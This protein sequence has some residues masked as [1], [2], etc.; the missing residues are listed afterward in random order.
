LDKAKRPCSMEKRP[1]FSKPLATGWSAVIACAVPALAATLS[2]NPAGATLIFEPVINFF[3]GTGPA[4]NVFPL[5]DPTYI[6]MAT[7]EQVANASK[8]GE[9]YKLSM[10]F[11]REEGM[12]NVGMYNNTAY[13]IT[14]LT[15]TIVGSSDE[16]DLGV[17]WVVTPDPNVDAF[18]D[19]ANNDGKVG[20]SDIFST[21]TVSNGGRTLTLSDGLIPAGSHFTDYIFSL[22]TDGAPSAFAALEGSFDGVLVPEPSTWAMMLL[23]F[24]GL[25]YAGFRRVK[26]SASAIA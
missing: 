24:A 23:G 19:D 16:L 20:L 3:P 22:T 7:G 12:V 2:S 15:M 4:D 10:G 25:G 1:M 11:P 26:A 5:Y 21:I 6:N 13:N 18:F 9:I 17:S 14:S 8:P